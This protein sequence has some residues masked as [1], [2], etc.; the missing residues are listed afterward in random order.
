VRGFAVQQQRMSPIAER[1][2][3]AAPEQ[4]GG[5]T[6]RLTGKEEHSDIRFQQ[7]RSDG[8]VAALG[9]YNWS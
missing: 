3:V 1:A 6:L 9:K 5:T 7:R 8:E 4:I 2:F